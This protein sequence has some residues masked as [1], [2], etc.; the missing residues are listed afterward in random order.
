MGQYFI[1]NSSCVQGMA[2]MDAGDAGGL[3]FY[4]QEMGALNRDISRDKT[5]TQIFLFFIEIASCYTVQVD[6]NSQ[7]CLSLPNV[8]IKGICPHI[9]LRHKYFSFLRQSH[10]VT[11][12]GL[13]LSLWLA[14]NLRDWLISFS[15]ILGLKVYITLVWD[16]KTF[17]SEYQISF[18][19]III[20]RRLH[21]E[22]ACT[23]Y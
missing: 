15:Q 19:C 3:Q 5:K 18:M 11:L 20:I 10:Y 23:R 21:M 6:S 12:A 2:R 1:P 17:K 16:L 14:S 8:R 13:E 7:P 22:K 4:S 9:W